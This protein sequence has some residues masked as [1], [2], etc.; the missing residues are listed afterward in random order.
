MTLSKS[1]SMSQTATVTIATTVTTTIELFLVDFQPGQ[2]TFLTSPFKS[3][4]HFAVARPKRVLLPPA[5]S[6]LAAGLSAFFA[7]LPFS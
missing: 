7:S 1:R 2:T 5:L 6:F 4:P 3:R